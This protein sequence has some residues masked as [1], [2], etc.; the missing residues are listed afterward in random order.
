M[1][2]RTLLKVARSAGSA[3]A[4]R[5]A[6]LRP[7]ACGRTGS[8]R[9]LAR[10]A[11]HAGAEEPARAARHRSPAWRRAGKRVVAVGQRGHVLFSDD[12]GEELAA[13]R[14]AG[15]RRSGGGVVSRTPSRAGRSATTA[16]ILHS[17]DGGRTWTRQLDGRTLGDVLVAY[18]SQA[19]ATT[20]WLAEAK[21][22]AAQG[23]ENPFLDVWFD[24]AAPAIVVG[25]FGLVLRTTDGGADLGAAAARHRQPQEPAPVRG[26]PHRRRGL[27]SPASRA[28][29]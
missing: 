22:F 13:G 24:D 21:R 17:A 19:A 28:C 29:C 6:A 9:A 14:S 11:G 5:A 3:V 10:R 25:A 2:R 12:A 7:A 4:A 20:K 8:F 1:Q 15:Q 16:S 23:A 18:Y 27:T 26:A